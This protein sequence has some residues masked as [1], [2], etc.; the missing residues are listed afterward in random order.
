MTGGLWSIYFLHA[1][2][3][4]WWETS[5][6][7]WVPRPS[8]HLWQIRK[9]WRGGS[10]WN[11]EIG[12]TSFRGISRRSD[13]FNND[14]LTR[15]FITRQ[16]TT[17]YSRG[18]LHR[19]PTSLN[20]PTHFRFIAPVYIQSKI[21]LPAFRKPAPRILRHNVAASQCDELMMTRWRQGT[22]SRRQIKIFV[23]GV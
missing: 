11:N 6:F 4:C 3:F 19:A 7:Y 12:Q 16:T 23:S 13:R 22:A 2:N 20:F 8:T 15:A 9:R 18:W 17:N 1:F 5:S 10:H 14:P 21:C